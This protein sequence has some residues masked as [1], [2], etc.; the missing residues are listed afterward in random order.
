MSA[1]LITVF[2]VSALIAFAALV[3]AIVRRR[4]RSPSAEYKRN[5]RDIQLRTYRQ[6][7]PRYTR[8]VGDDG[9]SGSSY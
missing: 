7:E 6:T 3:A 9:G 4:D 2:A 1:T 8:K 5:M